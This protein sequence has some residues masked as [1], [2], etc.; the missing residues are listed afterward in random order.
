MYLLSLYIYL[1][2]ILFIFIYIY[3]FLMY[4]FV[5]IYIYLLFFSRQP[6]KSS[7]QVSQ[8]SLG[9]AGEELQGIRK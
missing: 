7:N 5:F 3:L 1:F 8:N 6:G 4:L 9:R 2:I